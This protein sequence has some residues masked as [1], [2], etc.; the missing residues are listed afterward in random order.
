MKLKFL[1]R[2]AWRRNNMSIDY[3]P[4][5][6]KATRL[7][8]DKL[9]REPP[10]LRPEKFF[11]RLQNSLKEQARIYNNKYKP[12]AED[13]TGSAEGWLDDNCS[14]RLFGADKTSNQ[15]LSDCQQAAYAGKEKDPA[16]I[17]EMALVLMLQRLLPERFIVVR[18]S[19]YDDYNGSIDYEIIDQESG[20]VVC[21]V[22]E[23][24]DR[25]DNSGPNKK[26]KKMTD[27]MLAGGFRI[28]YGARILKGK[29]SLGELK[30]IPAFYMCINKEELTKLCEVLVNSPVDASSQFKNQ[31]E[32]SSF[33]NNLA[34]KL[35]SSLLQQVERYK[36]MPLKQELRVNIDNFVHSLEAW[37]IE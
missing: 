10:K 19:G 25:T 23:I 1:I 28:K 18:S 8:P 16:K 33:I 31:T 34:V 2:Y 15:Y 26:E 30:N 7:D 12:E 22:D 13:Q 32:H 6:E 24:I 21:G 9:K 14:I 27:K 4:G 37:P 20:N 36:A 3:L 29:L 35:R 11:D 5:I 17:T